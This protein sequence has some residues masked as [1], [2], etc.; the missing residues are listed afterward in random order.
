MR[1]GGDSECH[2]SANFYRTLA[3]SQR[4]L[5]LAIDIIS[6]QS[7][8]VIAARVLG[9]ATVDSWSLLGSRLLS[10]L[11]AGSHVF[12]ERHDRIHGVHLL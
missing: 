9:S 6:L 5:A 2:S 7:V 4:G 8:K 3:I 1:A 11:T 10:S 12:V